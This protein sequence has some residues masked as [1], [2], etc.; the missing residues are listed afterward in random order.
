MA[1]IGDKYIFIH[2]HK[3]GGKSVRALLGNPKDWGGLHVEA[4]QVK[5]YLYEAGREKEWDDAFKF[6]IVRNPYEWLA[7][8]YFYIKRSPRHPDIKYCDTFEG[9]V[10]W[11]I[12]DAMKRERPPDSNKYLTLTEFTEGMDYIAR[13]ETLDDDFHYIAR[14]CGV[15]HKYWHLN[16]NKYNRNLLYLYNRK[17]ISM[18]ND[19]FADDFKNFNYEMW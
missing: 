12:S 1:I 14:K 16:K 3:T 4:K 17:L 10:K 18:V 15:E 7:S 6:S 19:R 13:T 2:P 5:K 9:F 8:T 11:L